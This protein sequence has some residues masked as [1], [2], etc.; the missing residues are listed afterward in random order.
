M[1]GIVVVSYGKFVQELV[2]VVEYVVGLQ[3]VFEVFLIEVE[4]DID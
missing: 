2:C 3:D 1:I 4:D